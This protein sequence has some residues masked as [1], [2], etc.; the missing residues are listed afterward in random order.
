MEVSNDHGRRAR[1][2]RDELRGGGGGEGV[3]EEREEEGSEERER[4]SR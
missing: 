4:E 2:T 1:Q 3:R